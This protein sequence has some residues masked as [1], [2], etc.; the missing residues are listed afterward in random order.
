MAAVKGSQK[1]EVRSQ[2]GNAAT[3]IIEF[4]Y[5]AQAQESPIRNVSL[6][7]L[8]QH[9]AAILDRIWQ[10][11]REDHAQLANGQHVDHVRDVFRWMLDQAHEQMKANEKVAA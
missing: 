9:Y 3:V 2:K 11:L 6:T 7:N 10:G 8:P 1:S 5:A 4:S